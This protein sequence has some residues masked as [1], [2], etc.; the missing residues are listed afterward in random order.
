MV[1]MP[2]DG[3]G[4]RRRSQG[5]QTS[6]T[7]QVAVEDLSVADAARVLGMPAGTARRSLL[8]YRFRSCST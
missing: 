3:P 8:S 5:M 7:L 1:M 4:R 6:D 2:Y